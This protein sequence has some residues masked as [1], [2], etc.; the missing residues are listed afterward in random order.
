MRSRSFVLGALVA[1]GTAA[2][3]QQKLPV[4]ELAPAIAKSAQTF[5]TILNVRTLPGGNLLLNDATNRQVL[6]LDSELN[7]KSVVIDSTTGAPNSYGAFGTPIIPYLGDST[8]FVDNAS[9]SLLVIDPNG[10]VARVMA[11]P[12]PQDLTFLR[13]A[14]S[15]VD[16]KGRLLYRGF[17][18]PR[19]QR[20]APA[21]NGMPQIPTPPDSNPILRADFDTRTTDTIGKVKTQSGA[22][23]TIAQNADGQMVAKRKVNP[24]PAVDEWGVTS[25]GAVALVRGQDYHIDWLNPDGTQTSSPKMPFDWKRLSDEDKQKLIDSAKAAQEQLDARMA[26]A[27]KNGGSAP[28]A[29]GAAGSEVRMMVVERAAGAGMSMGGGGGGGGTP[30]PTNMTIPKME[31]EYPPISEIPDYYPPIRQGAVRPDQDGNLWILPTTSAQSQ[32]GELVYDVV[33]RKGELTQRVR[34]PVGRSIAGFGKGGIVYLMSQDATSK[35]W[36]LEKTKVLDW[37]GAQ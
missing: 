26:E 12:N 24:V 6:M 36:T 5:G 18:M 20:V 37:T 2:S 25:D 23:A 29:A 14:Q 19:N 32:A 22:R 13:G 9:Q 34:L 16:N 15:Y 30:M 27:M 10:K 33:N 7:K 4:R 28:G 21:A 3:A 17:G 31:T 8:L 11:A 35:Q 1:T